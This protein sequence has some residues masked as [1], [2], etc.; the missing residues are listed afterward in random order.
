MENYI[1]KGKKPIDELTNLVNEELQI[2][3]K[4]KD[5]NFQWPQAKKNLNISKGDFTL[6]LSAICGKYKINAKEF[7]ANLAKE[8]NEE[9]V[10]YY[11][12]I[13]IFFF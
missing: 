3:L 8:F 4:K 9:I 6:L 11:I 7:T 12:Y 2:F 13:L 10:F 5:S 1:L